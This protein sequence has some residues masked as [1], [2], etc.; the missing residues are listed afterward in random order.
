VIKFSF[1]FVLNFN[2]Q[3]YKRVEEEFC[4]LS[5]S[6][7]YDI[8]YSKEKDEVRF[9]CFFF[10]IIKNMQKA[11]EIAK[12]IFKRDLYKMAQEILLPPKCENIVL[13]IFI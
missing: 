7:L 13:F 9:F 11:K 2:F 8:Y 12:R 6:I 5:D 3:N 10:L 4:T 1:I